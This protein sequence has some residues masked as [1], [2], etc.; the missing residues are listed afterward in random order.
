MTTRI[1][2]ATIGLVYVIVTLTA[3]SMLRAGEDDAQLVRRPYLGVLFRAEDTLEIRG[4]V[5]GT[6]WPASGLKLGDTIVKFNER[7][8]S[9]VAEVLAA[10]KPFRVGDEVALLVRRDG[11]DWPI[12]LRLP[13]WPR[14]RPAGFEVLYDEVR[15]A[16]KSLRCLVTKPQQAS[17]GRVPA[18]FYIQGI[19]CASIESPFPGPNHMRQFVYSLTRAGFAVMRCEKS[20]VGDSTGPD[21]T[22]L[23]LEQEVSDFTAALQKLKSYDF[24]DAEKV[25]LFGHSAGGWTAPL[26]AARE[27]VAGIAV[28][29]TVVRP[30]GEYL[31]ENHRRNKWHRSHPDPAVLELEVR[32]MSRLWHLLLNERLTPADVLKAEPALSDVVQ[33]VFRGDSE[34]AYDVRS[35]G[36]FRDVHEQNMPAAW[37]KLRVPVLAMIGQYEVRCSPFEHE[38]IADIVNFHSPAKGTWKILPRLD[39]GFA[40]HDTIQDAVTNEFKG[41]FGKVVVSESVEWM[42]GVLVHGSAKK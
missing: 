36:Y 1:C 12:T 33:H 32:R 2:S 29:G 13:E 24:V 14:E 27:P 25:F 10:T 40:E 8:V 31:V 39:H 28:Y 19:D 11:G 6:E 23:G 5:S 3:H 41:P 4:F 42:R 37:A 34:L 16:T 38:Y 21:C 15:V 22:R 9:S 18:V 35:L 20:G 17:T 26:V 7:P 30:F